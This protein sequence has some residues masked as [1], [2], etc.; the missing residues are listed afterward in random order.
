M[1]REVRWAESAANDLEEIAEYIAKDSEHYAAAV[2]RELT[3]AAR[4]LARLAERGRVVPEYREA[5]IRELIVSNY[6]LVYEIGDQ[7]VHVLRIIHGARLLP[8]RR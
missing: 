7:V 4:S 3:D 2:V 1:D 6:R 8:D 5:A